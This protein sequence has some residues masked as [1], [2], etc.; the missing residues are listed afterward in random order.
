MQI[1]GVD[2]PQ[3]PIHWR[4]TSEFHGSL[5]KSNRREKAAQNLFQ[6]KFLGFFL[7]GQ[8]GQTKRFLQ[9]VH[10]QKQKNHGLTL[11]TKKAPKVMIGH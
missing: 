9:H 5:C 10:Q 2:R 4:H 6:T 7:K 8:N 11:T 1:M 3:Q